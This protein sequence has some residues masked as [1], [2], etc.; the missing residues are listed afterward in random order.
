[1]FVDTLYPSIRFG[2]E[3]F[4]VY[5]LLDCKDNTILHS[6]ANRSPINAYKRKYS[7]YIS[8]VAN[9]E[10]STALFAYST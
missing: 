4:R 10:F 5:D 9:P 8:S 1:M 7:V 6:Q 2:H 3:K